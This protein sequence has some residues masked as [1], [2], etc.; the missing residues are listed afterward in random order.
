MYK[1]LVC[2]L[3]CL[4]S[5]LCLSWKFIKMGKTNDLSARKLPLVECIIQEKR[6]IQPD[7]TNTLN[8]SYASVSR[9]KKVLDNDKH[10]V[11]KCGRKRII[12]PKTV[13]KLFQLEKRDIILTSKDLSK[14]QKQYE[15]H[16]SDQQYIAN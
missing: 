12:S 8:I 7:I 13:R 10:R 2:E 1:D 6:Y 4:Y 11:G 15:V 5:V 14:N 9:V 3:E 16:Y